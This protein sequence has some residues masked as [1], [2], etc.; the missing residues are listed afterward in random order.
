[1][2]A[3]VK[4]TLATKPLVVKKVIMKRILPDSVGQAQEPTTAKK[5][6]RLQ[7]M[8]L[9]KLYALPPSY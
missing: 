6:A 3:G 8:S 4:M 2:E 1:M 9:R 7:L 5:E